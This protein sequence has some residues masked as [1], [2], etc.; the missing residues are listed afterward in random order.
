[1]PRIS[2]VCVTAKPARTHRE[3]REW[4]RADVV[5]FVQ[6][7]ERDIAIA[8][9]RE[10]LAYERWELLCIQLC[11]RLIDEAIRAQGGEVLELYNEAL[12]TGFA[13]KVFPRTSPQA[14]TVLP[15][16][17]HHGLA[18]HSSTR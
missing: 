7:E 13:C 10:V 14:A 11:D 1:M 6:A 4:E 17:D 9:A 16:F 3:F 5:V 18:K 12:A 15:R 8:K 2:R